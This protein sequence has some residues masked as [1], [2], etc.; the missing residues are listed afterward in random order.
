MKK[1]L[2]IIF[3]AACAAILFSALLGEPSEAAEKKPKGQKL[4]DNYIAVFDIET[5]GVDKKI[6]KPL[7]ES[8]RREL[9]MS[10]KYEVI[11][12]GNMNK[13]LG[14][15]KLQFSGCVAGQCIVEAGQLLGVG[16]IITGSVNIVG[17]TYYLTLSLINVE[18]G[19]IE[20]VSEDK[21]KC[22]IDDLI[23]STKRLVKR[24]LGEQVATPQ[25]TVE[26]PKPTETKSSE[27]KQ[28]Q[29]PP[30]TQQPPSSVIASE[31]KQSLTD[32]PGIEMVF[33][34]GGCYQMGESY[35]AHEV[36]LDDFYL[37]KYEVTQ[38]QWK[39]IMGNN[40]SSFKD[41]GDN[42]PV[43]AVSWNDIQDFIQKLNRKTKNNP[44]APSVASR[45]DFIKGEFRLPTEAE[46]EYA[47]RSGGKSEK[48]SGTSNESEIGDYAWYEKNSG[49][50]THSVGQKKPNGLG[51]YDMSGN[52]WEWVNDWYD[53]DY[54][55][56]SPKN[57]P[58][59]PSSGKEK[60]L[61]GGSWDCFSGYLEAS[62]R[63]RNVPTW[64]GYGFGFRVAGSK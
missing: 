50:K 59:G 61:R 6:S 38:G 7:T 19:K 35:N 55:K 46:W 28:S 64:R 31:A 32:A 27:T 58:T 11:D 39:S 53:G 29:Q 9:V 21:C 13:I 57:N 34:K 54:Y 2:I 4:M 17:K 56:N 8:I 63:D 41:C 12:R 45:T 49:D 23:D 43:E 40:P 5:E 48:Y 25:T 20:N 1:A 24:L 22:E 16:K 36:C 42:C 14:E 10:G 15:Q 3:I 18:T 47:A 37:G 30:S 51:L 52:V 60:V 44:Q 33:V 62:F 26:T